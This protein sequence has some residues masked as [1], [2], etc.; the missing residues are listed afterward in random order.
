MD[1]VWTCTSAGSAHSPGCVE[2]GGSFAMTCPR[3]PGHYFGSFGEASA[4]HW[5][6][7]AERLPRRKKANHSSKKQDLT[8]H[9]LLTFGGYPQIVKIYQ[10]MILK[11]YLPIK[12][13][14][15][16]LIQ[17]WSYQRVDA[18]VLK[19]AYMPFHQN[20]RTFPLVL[21][22]VVLMTYLHDFSWDRWS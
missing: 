10:N 14:R 3:S 9:R 17:V 5:P 15:G 18:I 20:K 1:C 4:G 11:W 2:A 16:L 6:N 21:R 12:Q 7:F 8:Y 22:I 19:E 13:P